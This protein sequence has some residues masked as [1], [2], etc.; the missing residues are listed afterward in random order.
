MDGEHPTRKT[1]ISNSPLGRFL[2]NRFASYCSRPP[3][4]PHGGSISTSALFHALWTG[5]DES[6]AGKNM[7]STKG[8]DDARKQFENLCDA[9]NKAQ[10]PKLAPQATKGSGEI[11]EQKTPPFG[12]SRNLLF[13]GERDRMAM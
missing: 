12:V 5:L 13:C 6:A 4:W 8:M 1:N 2:A 7:A 3:N 11:L 9:L 10:F